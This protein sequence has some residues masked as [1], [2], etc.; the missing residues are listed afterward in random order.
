MFSLLVSLFG[1]RPFTL[2]VYLI[3]RK[4]DKDFESKLKR[5]TDGAN[6][7]DL[8]LRPYSDTRKKE[9]RYPEDVLA[10]MIGH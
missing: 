5:S 10:L 9:Q 4:R 7:G 1:I 6:P 3:A 2:G 8:K